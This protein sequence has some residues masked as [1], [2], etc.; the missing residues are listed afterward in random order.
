LHITKW[1]SFE[2]HSDFQEVEDEDQE[3]GDVVTIT[4]DHKTS[5]FSIWVNTICE[6][7]TIQY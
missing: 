2:V 1:S 4:G 3:E 5:G 7:I 6:G